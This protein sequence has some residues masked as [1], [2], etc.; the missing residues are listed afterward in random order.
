M[1][2][3]VVD[4]SRVEGITTTKTLSAV[5]SFVINT[6]QFL[7]RFS[8]VC[9]L[10]LNGISRHIQQL[11]ISLALLEAKLQSIPGL[12]DA[13]GGA[14]LPAPS[15][16]GVSAPAPGAAAAPVPSAAAEAVA[17]P[18]VLAEPETPVLKMKDDARYVRYFKMLSVGVPMAQVKQKMM[19]DGLPPDVLDNPDAP[20][21]AQ[22]SVLGA[23]AADPP[24]IKDQGDGGD[25]EF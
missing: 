15:V 12:N 22:G 1:V 14:P 7:N 19:S 3:P 23:P 16:V 18:P 11:E 20:S 9:E 24:A 8:Y 5:N 2:E 13:V 4:Y 10:K 17:A 21:D 25:D 6:T